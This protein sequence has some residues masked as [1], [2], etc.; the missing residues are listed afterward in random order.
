[1]PY[2]CARTERLRAV[3]SASG[4]DLQAISMIGFL[5]T[6]VFMRSLSIGPDGITPGAAHPWHDDA[7]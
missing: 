1:M 7:G 4:P 3:K 6:R 5:A 2:G